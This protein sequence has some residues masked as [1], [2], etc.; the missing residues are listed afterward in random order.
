VRFAVGLVVR[1]S[2]PGCP[3]AQF[4]RTNEDLFNAGWLE[5]VIEMAHERIHLLSSG[6]LPLGLTAVDLVRLGFCDPV[7]LFNKDE[8]HRM[9]KLKEGRVRLIMNV[10]LVDQIVERVLYGTSSRAEILCHR[11]LQQKPGMGLDDESGTALH[12]QVRELS[13]DTDGE[14]VDDDCS[15]WDFSYQ[16][17]DQEAVDESRILQLNCE[18]PQRWWERERGSALAQAIVNRGQCAM[19]SVYCFSDGRLVEQLLKGVQLSGRYETSSGNSKAR[20]I[21]STLAGSKWCLS[22][23]D[24]AVEDG[25]KFAE[26]LKN[27]LKLGKVVKQWQPASAERFEFCSSRFETTDGVTR[28]VGLNWEKMLCQLLNK[29]GT[30]TEKSGWMLQ[31]QMDLRHSPHLPEVLE[32][33]Q[34]S[35]WFENGP[36]A[37]SVSR[38]NA[39]EI[40]MPKGKK[41]G[42]ATNKS[43]RLNK[44]MY[45]TIKTIRKGGGYRGGQMPAQKAAAV[46]LG[47]PMRTKPLT[48]SAGT[49]PGSLI[50][51][52]CDYLTDVVLESSNVAGDI[53]VNGSLHPAGW[54]PSRIAVLG[55]IFDKF[56]VKKA[57]LMLVPTC[58]TTTAGG[59][60]M[61]F[62]H[63]P[64]E[65]PPS[66]EDGVRVAMAHQ[67]ASSAPAWSENCARWK[68]TDPET[69]YYASLEGADTEAGERQIVQG[70]FYVICNGPSATTVTIGQL[71]LNY[72]VEFFDPSLD[73]VGESNSS[74]GERAITTVFGSTSGVA[75]LNLTSPMGSTDASIK[76]PGVV[77]YKLIDSLNLK[78]IPAG[79]W[80]WTWVADTEASA[81]GGAGVFQATDMDAVFVDAA[82][83]VQDPTVVQVLALSD[84]D[85]NIAE[86]YSVVSTI[87]SWITT[88][89]DLYGSVQN[90]VDSSGSWTPSVT[91]SDDLVAVSQQAF[92]YVLENLLASEVP[93]VRRGSCIRV[94]MKDWARVSVPKVA[95]KQRGLHSMVSSNSKRIAKLMADSASP[96]NAARPTLYSQLTPQNSTLGMPRAVTQFAAE[97]ALVEHASFCNGRCNGNCRT[98]VLT[99]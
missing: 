78:H 45:K 23:G 17:W 62:D 54:T 42:K 96:V 11:N 22:Q 69:G 43:K 91:S 55:T 25:R 90:I 14:V 35:G 67:G 44:Q 16:G 73:T 74:V 40:K 99:K 80:K 15:G 20:K 5:D 34:Q 68:A 63:D 82:G 97:A 7:R 84:T 47:G 70:Q 72:E 77:D 10:S 86:G 59:T 46:A 60:L 6:P 76:V 24:D 37:L 87:T 56:N 21:N 8:P 4:G 3:L 81:G 50:A 58:P 79:T 53:L 75:N 83:D 36:Q 28:V 1:E 94:T 65:L 89:I 9:A 48:F 64:V 27:Y 2:G 12:Q 52:G 39:C 19:L 33:A 71:F 49:K 29:T 38:M 26:R 18:N 66:G 61:Y 93:K 31:V 13:N 51:R 98:L 57:D 92:A 41:A 95:K 88:A 32:I 85:R 30:H